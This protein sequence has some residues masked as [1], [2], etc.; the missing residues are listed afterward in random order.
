VP[1]TI[2]HIG[3]DEPRKALRVI[4]R[5]EP[6]LISPSKAPSGGTQTAYAALPGEH[7]G[8]G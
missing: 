3:V 8:T 1:V 2:E 6:A 5:P 4:L 7:S